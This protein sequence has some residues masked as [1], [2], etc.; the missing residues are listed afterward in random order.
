LKDPKKEQG[1]NIIKKQE[2]KK[3]RDKKCKEANLPL[4]CPSEGIPEQGPPREV[5]PTLV[6]NA[7]SLLELRRLGESFEGR[8]SQRPSENRPSQDSLVVRGKN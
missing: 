7:Y 8:S 5:L 4:K 3:Q 1:E 2:K 6:N